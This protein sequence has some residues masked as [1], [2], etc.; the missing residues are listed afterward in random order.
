MSLSSKIPDPETRPKTVMIAGASGYL[1]RYLVQ[2]YA[3]R[4]W[5]VKAL[6]RRDA[7]LPTEMVRAEAT[8]PGTLQGTMEDV[9]LVISA[10]GITRQRDGL[11]YRDVDYQ[12]NA[13]LLA[14]AVH[15]GVPRFAYIHVLGSE[16]MAH[17]PL[18]AAKREFVELLRAA[19]LASTVVAPS[20]YF[21]DMGDFL[22]MAQA[23]RVWIFGPG[24][25]RINP[26]HGADLAHAT[27]QAIEAGR[28]WL[29]VGGP[30]A[31][32]HAELAK[33]A[34][35]ILDKPPR[36]T[37]LPDALRRIALHV[38]P[39]VTPAHIHG[40]ALFFLTAMG[41]DMVGEFHG[42]RRL[43][44]HFRDLARNNERQQS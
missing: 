31:F 24:V 21:S 35:D 5:H 20:G 25:H 23:G 39:W 30:E 18:V 14:E 9:D 29:D 33:L 12:A 7:D 44:D 15:A 17:V 22:S 16:R 11:T 8:K 40:P 37:R 3:R 42:S 43:A 34:F 4:G 28:D 2:E 41:D 32:S 19:P 26:I 36:I 13:N 1:G 6:V 27:A 38:L 10:L